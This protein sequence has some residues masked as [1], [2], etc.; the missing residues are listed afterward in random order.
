[1]EDFVAWLQ[2]EDHPCISQCL[3]LKQVEEDAKKQA[4]CPVIGDSMLS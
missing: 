4:T 2:S 1:M 3:S